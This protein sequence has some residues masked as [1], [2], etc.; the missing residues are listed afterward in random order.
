LNEFKDTFKT[1][2]EFRKFLNKEKSW[3]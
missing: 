1:Y 3:K 2:S